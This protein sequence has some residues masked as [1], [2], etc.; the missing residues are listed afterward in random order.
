MSN[1]LIQITLFDLSEH[2]HNCYTIGE[3]L[4]KSTAARNVHCGL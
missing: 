2:L 4:G 3:G 1:L